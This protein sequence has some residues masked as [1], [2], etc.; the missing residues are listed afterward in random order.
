ML[1]SGAG[2]RSAALGGGAEPVGSGDASSESGGGLGLVAVLE[3]L[4][5]VLA[6][7]MAL[8][9]KMLRQEEEKEKAATSAAGVS[10]RPVRWLTSILTLSLRL[11]IRY[12]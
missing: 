8:S 4:Q 11:V 5:S 7:E 2:E 3:Q 9:L 10:G 1:T 6:G 12:Y